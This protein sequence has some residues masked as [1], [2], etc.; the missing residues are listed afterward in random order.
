MDPQ[1]PP[2]TVR[3][4]HR[5][6][7]RR[8][9]RVWALAGALLLALVVLATLAPSARAGT[10]VAV[11]CHPA[12]DLAA[13]DATFTRTSDH[14]ASAKACAGN[15]PGLQIRNDSQ[16]TKDGRYGAWSWRPPAGTRFAQITSE[17]HVVHDAGHKGHFTAT[18]EGGTVHGRWPSEGSWQAVE[19]GAG[20]AAV[21]YTAWMMCHQ[22]SCGR[23]PGAHTHVRRLWFTLRDSS[24]PSLDLTGS[25]FHPGPRRGP[26]HATL[27]GADS[28]GGVWRWRVLVNG[29]GVTSSESSCDI[30]PSGPARRFVP[31]PLSSEQT[32]QLDTERVPFRNGVNEVT[33]CVTDVGWPANQTCRTRRVN[34]D[35]AC[36]SS[37]S[38]AAARIDAAF[39]RGRTTA[40][41]A[42]NR[43]ARVTGR[44]APR[45]G[46]S[47]G[48]A[49]LCVF[50]RVA[51]RP[52]VLEGM[53]MAAAAGELSFTARRGPSRRLRLAHRWGSEQVERILRLRI[54]VRPRLKVWP[55]K[56]LRNGQVAS[57]RG[58]LPGPDAQ[59][60]VVVLQARV[61]TRWQAFKSA[62]TGP[63][64]S[65]RARYRFRE[66]T[67][68]RLYRFR[69]IVREQAG[70]PYLKGASPVRRV[71]VSP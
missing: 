66:T 13:A 31:C 16:T 3:T 6:G 38:G 69:A 43:R 35:N 53:V 65:F 34:V 54:R 5:V 36:P 1:A 19:W 29:I 33:A 58:K 23:G 12:Y 14:Y 64:G 51:G 32:F 62:R 37:G 61:G 70:Y 47:I 18:D 15:G 49:K 59:G 28:G 45:G 52:E 4:W 8:N 25:L 7:A 26:Q 57:F 63:D 2:R 17:G 68:R 55:R 39:P 41:V 60:R 11:Q 22:D 44:I 40:T 27:R 67:A 50:S 10:Y 56:R 48:G 21:A 46:G 30:V 42:S 20:T 71:V 9:T 24:Q